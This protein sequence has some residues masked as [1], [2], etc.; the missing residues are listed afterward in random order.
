[1][2]FTCLNIC[3][4]SG[5]QVVCDKTGIL[6]PKHLVSHDK[7]MDAYLVCSPITSDSSVH[8][9]FATNHCLLHKLGNNICSAHVYYSSA[10]NGCF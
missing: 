3:F 6:I 7:L 4:T 5:V 10:I 2:F 1:M 9:S 8:N